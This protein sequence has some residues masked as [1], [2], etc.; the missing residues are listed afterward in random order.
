[1][2]AS[3]SPHVS[4]TAIVI[5]QSRDFP[6][7]SQTLVAL[8]EQSVKPQQVLI[9]LEEDAELPFLHRTLS[10]AHIHVIGRQT[11]FGHA[12]DAVLAQADISGDWLWLIHADSAPEADA[13][14]HMIQVA[15]TS[16]QIGAVGPKQVSWD[17]EPRQLLEVGINAT[18]SARRVPEIEMG[19]LDQGQL[20]YRTDVLAVGTA[21]MLVRSQAWDDA[22]GID[23]ALG[24]F[25]DG[26][27]FSRRLRSAG[28]RVVVEPRARIRHAQVSLGRPLVGSFA[29]RRTNQLYNA[30][31]AAPAFLVPFL[32][33][34]YVLGSIPRAFLRLLS[35]DVAYAKAELVAGWS[36]VT[37]LHA[38][39]RGR[40]RIRRVKVVPRRALKDLEARPW[41]IRQA[42][43]HSRRARADAHYMAVAPDQF[44][45]KERAQYQRQSKIG[46]IVV[47]V[48]SAAIAGLLFLP[49]AFNGTV[50]GGGLAH[51]S[52]T[53]LEIIHSA[54]SGW[55]ASGDGMPGAIDP[56]WV[57]LALPLTVLQPLH[58]TLGQLLTVLIYIAIPLVGL[59][60]YA[61]IGRIVVSWQARVV[62]ALVWILSPPFID[63]L[64]AGRI[65]GIVAYIGLTGCAYTLGNVW[66]GSARDAGLLAFFGMLASLASPIFGL[67]L[68]L[69]GI[70]ATIAQRGR[71]RWIAISLPA[72]AVHAPGVRFGGWQYL[73]VTPGVPLNDSG[74]DPVAVL[75]LVPYQSF[76]LSFPNVLAYAL[77]LSMAA[78]AVFVLARTTLYG[79]IRVAWLFAILG[80][81]WALLATQFVHK[82]ITLWSGFGLELVWISLTTAI[83]CGLAGARSWLR[84]A[85]FGIKHLSVGVVSLILGIG[86]VGTSAHLIL[87]NDEILQLHPQPATL[88]PAIGLEDQRSG[89][90]VLYLQVASNGVEAQLWRGYGIELTEWTMVEQARGAD[91]A[92]KEHLGQTVANIMGRSASV[93]NDLSEHGVSLI[94][95]PRSDEPQRAELVA[96]LNASRGLDYVSGHES[97]DFWRVT[98]SASNVVVGYPDRTQQI[99]PSDRDRIIVLAERYGPSWRARLNG[100]L[101]SVNKTGWQQSF[102]LPAGEHGQLIVSNDDW[103]HRGL[104]GLMIGAMILSI[105]A[106]LPT[107]RKGWSR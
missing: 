54:F 2:S 72:L 96:A 90:K 81:A 12:V 16:R 75:S 19:E 20:D 84:A 63:A 70:V 64:G 13:L 94:V 17:S 6:Y 69:A 4:I 49:I 53:G 78:I 61:A 55:I 32:W 71:W 5:S 83:A 40:E 76:T 15:E 107:F 35:K 97:G 92:A 52:A 28:Y 14:E 95:V 99:R 102:V 18:R 24:P 42:K 29:R 45:I 47:A 87:V 43:R 100:K 11:S 51:S 77:P 30:L 7:L 60:A 57:F 39:I 34:G 31:L 67:I 73:L 1:M 101:L 105:F 33:C 50:V 9:G 103:T 41:S 82:D 59:L 68:A 48:I 37:R 104:V 74:A 26:L 23:P 85:S 46:R 21:G 44:T 88:I 27:E 10:H 89:N 22:G 91:G 3:E 98:N 56:L 86:L 8:S 66:R 106:A 36:L 93:A 58:I 65:S 38:I 62:L 80:L 25:G 79:R